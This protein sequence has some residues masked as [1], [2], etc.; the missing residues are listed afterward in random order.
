MQKVKLE[1]DVLVVETFDAGDREPAE[2]GTVAAHADAVAQ[3]TLANTCSH[4]IA[5]YYTRGC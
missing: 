2:R 4:E 1:M 3:A 5:C